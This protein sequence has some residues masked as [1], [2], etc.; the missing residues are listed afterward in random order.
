[1]RQ[2]AADIDQF[3][4]QAPCRNSAH[5]NQY[6]NRFQPPPGHPPLWLA[7]LTAPEIGDPA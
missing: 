2:V 6:A 4:A 1:V 5:C 3:H 7:A